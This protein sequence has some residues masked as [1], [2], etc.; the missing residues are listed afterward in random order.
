MLSEGAD[1]GWYRRLVKKRRGKEMHGSTTHNGPQLKFTAR[2]VL[3]AELWFDCDPPQLSI[4]S[5]SRHILCYKQAEIHQ[6]S[7]HGV[8]MLCQG[9]DTKIHVALSPVGVFAPGAAST[10]SGSLDKLSPDDDRDYF[11]SPGL[12][13][14]RSAR[15]GAPRSFS[16]FDSFS[17]RPPWIQTLD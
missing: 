8:L 17:R 4:D 7:L 3:A 9:S 10:Q 11:S 2:P 5:T 12:M 15:V 14:M 16:S 1:I 6:S 13:Q